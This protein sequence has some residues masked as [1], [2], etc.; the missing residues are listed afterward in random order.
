MPE[1]FKRSRF[2]WEEGRSAS[3]KRKREGRWKP[4]RESHKRSQEDWLNQHVGIC[5]PLWWCPIRRDKTPTEGYWRVPGNLLEWLQVLRVKNIELRRR[6]S[7]RAGISL[8]EGGR[9][10]VVA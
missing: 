4:F 7:G 5:T 10:V 9:L 6:R 3:W 8:L 1:K 2:S